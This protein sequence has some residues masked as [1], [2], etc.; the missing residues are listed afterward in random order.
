MTLA[1]FATFEKDLVIAARKLRKNAPFTLVAL[2]T[3]ALGIGASTAIFSVVNAVLLRP[4][5]Y[6][7]AD[8]LV[9]V[10]SDLRNRDVRDFPLPPAD[11]NDIRQQ[12]GLFEGF[13]AVSPGRVALTGDGGQPERVRIAGV[14]PNLVGLLGARIAF[15]RDFLEADATPPPPPD[16][17]E[18]AAPPPEIVN[19]AILT[20]GFWQ[21][22]YGGDPDILGK[23]LQLGGGKAEVVGVLAPGFEL[24]FPPAVNVERVPDLLTAMRVDFADASPLS[25]INVFLRVIGRL[26]EGVTLAQAQAQLDGIAAALRRQFPIKQTSG[27]HLRTESMYQDLVMDV[28]PVILTLMGA[29]AFVLLIA[30]ANVANLLLVRASARERELAVRAALGGSRWHLVSQT[31]AESVLL[32]GGGALLGLLL[33]RLGIRLLLALRPADLP[34]LDSVSLDPAV[35]AFTAG[36]TVLAAVLSGVMPALRA[37][38]PDIADVLRE[39]GRTAGLGSGRLR[40]AVVVAEVALCFVLLIG[41]GLMIRSFIALQRTDPGYQAEGLLTFLLPVPPSRGEAAPA[42]IQEFRDRL[43]AVPG[44]RSVTSASALPL[45]GTSPLARWG[46]PEA[47]TDPSLFEQ[48]APFFVLPGYFETMRTPL[49]DGRT[50]TEAD[51]RQDALVMVIDELLAARAYPNE[52]AVGKRLLVRVRGPE[53]ELLEVIGVVR[54]QRATTLAADGEEA[55]FF[56]DGFAGGGGAVGRWALRTAG[57]PTSLAPAVRAEIQ[58]FEPLAAVADMQPMTD[59]VDRA[60]TPTRFAL[61]LIAVFAI[62]AAL[63]AAVGLYGVLSTV[64]RQRTAEI[65]VRMAFGAPRMSIFRLFVGQG[66][67]LSVLGIAL[68]TVASLA[69]TRVMTGMLVEVRPTDPTTFVAVALVFFSIAGIASWLPARRAARLDP[70]AALRE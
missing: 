2:I 29:V 59:L 49:I 57:D 18:A 56:T 4:L 54:H 55:M 33:A 6:R 34:R 5:P 11:F 51:N 3:V 40:N 30:C 27:M 46:R 47:A 43:G 48:G 58:R 44:V 64:V 19:A 15:G 31:L 35:L 1:A 52:S 45:E 42:F 8:R 39:I 20:H 23:V 16:T 12:A 62:I 61:A 17:T 65:G 10:W 26:K 68:G 36:A 63:L 50:F 22:R 38:R 28:R 69:M 24:L 37:S 67:R 66:L 9:L 25:R 53:P 13:A 41:S 70:T 60:R 32:A 21:R 7:D 14:T